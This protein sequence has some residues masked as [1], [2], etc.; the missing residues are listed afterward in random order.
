MHGPELGSTTEEELQQVFIA[1]PG[2][3]VRWGNSIIL[4]VLLLLLNL[5]WL[6]KWPIRVDGT[7]V[8]TSMR[9]PLS[10]V[11]KTDGRI[12][13]LFV[14]SGDY[15]ENGDILGVIDNPALLSEVLQLE[16]SLRPLELDLSLIDKA[17]F[18]PGFHLGELQNESQTF[19]GHVNNYRLYKRTAQTEK[20][21][22]AINIQ[23]E[24][25]KQLLASA[26]LQRET[27]EN[28]LELLGKDFERDKHLFKANVVAE[29]EL[30]RKQFEV[31]SAQSDFQ[32]A[33]LNIS[34]SRIKI[35]EI[36]H[37]LVVKSIQREREIAELEYE[38]RESVKNLLNRIEA[39]KQKYVL[40]SSNDGTVT[41]FKYWSTGQHVSYGS[42]VL[43]IVP[44]DQGTTVGK[45]LITV[46]NAARVKK[47]QRVDIYL[48]SFPFEEYG[49]L[50]GYVESISLVPKENKYA[51]DVIFPNGMLTTYGKTIGFGFELQGTAQI[52]TDD[53]N[54]IQRL[55]YMNRRIVKD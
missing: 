37:L 31:L 4:I 27:I 33:L 22:E 11:A 49:K 29:R 28:R 7:I 1:S 17:N 3:P 43:T 18:S 6:I 48:D 53:L 51:V 10:V 23:L 16:A 2:W 25:N 40:A 19:M 21:I 20:E 45:V 46:V 38:L 54:I 35:K 52:I 13:S 14:K 44:H 39:W 24:D 42:E 30:E 55:I 5:T 8:V 12:H 15:V 34:H 32:N 41:L 50:M 9:P 47:G 26:E 36:E